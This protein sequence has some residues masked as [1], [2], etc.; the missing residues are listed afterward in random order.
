MVRVS[1]RPIRLHRLG[2]AFRRAD[3][4]GLQ[5]TNERALVMTRGNAGYTTTRSSG[6][7]A[8]VAVYVMHTPI[9]RGGVSTATFMSSGDMNVAFLTVGSIRGRSTGW[10]ARPAAHLGPPC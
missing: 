5:H 9:G 8:P 4:G 2:S 1:G 6:R 10:P 7:E 3:V